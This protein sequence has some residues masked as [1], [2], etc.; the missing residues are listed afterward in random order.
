M[1]DV[2][3][4]EIDQ[5]QAER[6]KFLRDI[7]YTEHLLD[8]TSSSRMNQMSK[9]KL[10][11]GKINSRASVIST[12]K[13]ELNYLDR[14]IKLRTADIAELTQELELLK[15]DYARMIQ[16]AYQTK[17]SYDKAQY[18]L[19]ANDFNQAYKRI[20]YMQ[21]Y[22]Q[23]RREQATGI[24]SKKEY[25]ETQIEN[26]KVDQ[27][28]KKN[29][30]NAQQNEVARLNNEKREKDQIVKSLSKTESQLKKQLNEKRTAMMK[31][32]EEINNLIA[33]ATKTGTE[34]GGMNL[35]PEMKILSNEFGQNKSRLPWPVERGVVISKYGKHKHEVLTKV[36]VD[37]KGIDIA[38]T[39]KS[40]VRA[41]FSGKVS[42]VISI[43]GANLTIILQHGEYFTVYQNLIN[44]KV[45]KGDMVQAKQSLGEVYWD[46]KSGNSEI[47]FQLWKGNDN[48]NPEQWLAK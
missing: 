7:Q 23:F 32:E 33:K 20:R 47:H 18:I 46:G 30:L 44:L 14:D 24:R 8:S 34:G 16:K 22:N 2:N 31:V 5:L 6:E 11:S 35:T 4:Q 39:P 1:L 29:L 28:K 26:L 21:Q 10:L 15:K 48:Q 36:D 19:A 12:I 43:K 40:S 13:K 3:A 25:L 27:E 42:N 38:T 41:V 37:N 45:K 17:R 9:L